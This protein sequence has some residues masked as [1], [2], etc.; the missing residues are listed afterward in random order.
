MK[1]ADINLEPVHM[2]FMDQDMID[3]WERMVA[4]DLKTYRL[5]GGT[6]LA[7]Y[8]NHRNSTD[9]DF[10]RDGSVTKAEIEKFTWLR[11]AQFRGT[12]GMVDAMMPASKRSITINFISTRSFNGI[13]PTQS[14]IRAANG[15]FV[16]HPVDILTG[17]LS[18]MSRRKEVRDFI[19]IASAHDV[20]P[21]M[22]QDAIDVYLQD[23]MTQEASRRELAKTIIACPQA[24]EYELSDQLLKLLSALT[25][26]LSAPEDGNGRGRKNVHA[27][28]KNA[29]KTTK[30]T[31]R[32]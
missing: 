18:A 28:S 13:P 1:V 15:I 14:P 9:F 11:G 7:M 17:K 3:L 5:Y 21:D 20:I 8:L 29:D 19:D 25:E 30:R 23:S 26:S 16:A 32:R 6:A 12:S 31:D 24:V 2:D 22:L 4:H 27:S 10:F